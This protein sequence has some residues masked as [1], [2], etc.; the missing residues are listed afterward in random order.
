MFPLNMDLKIGYNQMKNRV[1]IGSYWK[2]Y[3]KN[4]S[5][6]IVVD[7]GRLQVNLPHLDNKWVVI[8]KDKNTGDLWIRPIEDFL[9]GRFTKIE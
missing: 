7:I 8:Y 3:K 6:Y 2:H 4:N 1:E 5:I 9:D